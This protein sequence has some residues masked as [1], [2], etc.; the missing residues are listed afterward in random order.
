[1][2]PDTSEAEALRRALLSGLDL[3]SVFKATHP[4]SYYLLLTSLRDVVEHRGDYPRLTGQSAPL[5]TGNPFSTAPTAAPSGWSLPTLSYETRV[6]DALEHCREARAL[7]TI[8]HWIECLNERRLGDFPGPAQTATGTGLALPAPG[9]GFDPGEFLFE[10]LR[11]G[12]LTEA[13]DYLQAHGYRLRAA[14]LLG[15][16]PPYL[17]YRP[18]QERLQ[19]SGNVNVLSWMDLAGR[20]SEDKSYAPYERA[21]FGVLSGNP[22]PM[23]QYLSHMEGR[24]L[25][26]GFGRRFSP[27]MT[28]EDRLWLFARSAYSGFL[29]ASMR[30]SPTACQ[31][32]A[33]AYA[34]IT[35]PLL[36]DE[37]R[38]VVAGD[39]FGL[40]DHINGRLRALWDSE[41]FDELARLCLFSL[42]II[43]EL[44]HLPTKTAEC[45]K[46]LQS[47][48]DIVHEFTE[49]YLERLRVR[50]EEFVP[51]ILES[52]GTAPLATRAG[53]TSFDFAS[54]RIVPRIALFCGYLQPGRAVE[55]L[56]KLTLLI[57]GFY[58]VLLDVSEE[59][60]RR[61]V[62]NSAGAQDWVLIEEVDASGNR[63]TRSSS[64]GDVQLCLTE[65]RRRCLI[66]L[67]KA[68]YHKPA[69]E[70]LG[71]FVFH[72][73]TGTLADGLSGGLPRP[74]GL[75]VSAFLA[76][77]LC[78]SGNPEAAHR[79]C[80][81]A[82]HAF[83]FTS[84]AGVAGIEEAEAAQPRSKVEILE[85]ILKRE[86][87]C[88][89]QCV[90][91]GLLSGWDRAIGEFYASL[92]KLQA[93]GSKAPPGDNQWIFQD[94]EGYGLV[95]AELRATTSNLQS[96]FDWL[97]SG[98]D[99]AMRML[100]NGDLHHYCWEMDNAEAEKIGL[101]AAEDGG[102]PLLSISQE[103]N[104]LEKQYVA[105]DAYAEL[106]KE[107]HDYEEA[108]ASRVARIRS[109][110][111]EASGRLNRRDSES[112]RVAE[113][114]S[115][116]EA[117]A[118]AA[119]A[120]DTAAVA[121]TAGIEGSDANADDSL[122]DF[123]PNP[124][125]TREQNL[126]RMLSRS[127][128]LQALEEKLSGKV[129]LQLCMG[130]A[131]YSSAMMKF[132]AAVTTAEKEETGQRAEAVS[133]L[134]CLMRSN[135]ELT[136]HFRDLSLLPRKLVWTLG[137]PRV[138]YLAHA[139]S[140][141]DLLQVLAYSYKANIASLSDGDNT[142]RQSSSFPPSGRTHAM[143]CAKPFWFGPLRSRGSSEASLSVDERVGDPPYDQSSYQADYPIGDSIGDSIGNSIGESAGDS[144]VAG[145]L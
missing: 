126:T 7:R 61:A 73:L 63:V 2:P 109:E 55:I 53:G 30:Q 24:R 16:I 87:A 37:E 36:T 123:F 124:Q 86:I 75:L 56:L 51:E 97:C 17:E 71:A 14:M 133:Q 47:Y 101:L 68:L 93:C 82:E 54:D 111:R 100:A 44:S 34:R 128:A 135:E 91:Y 131:E 38:F 5:R 69:V 25:G 140:R 88:I 116:D 13:A 4:Q 49:Y 40:F 144:V 137:V 89:D 142:R 33:A 76:R 125:L 64:Y 119:D 136:S 26:E 6:R 48:Q 66:E 106:K 43:R 80:E 77:D 9:P 12:K 1:M 57:R 19:M 21:I 95:C 96:V 121:N 27:G 10:Y 107:R 20:L 28:R 90:K 145:G 50:T 103:L 141:E 98:L 42:T 132:G 79:V 134:R 110:E 117:A 59:L 52:Q 102:G 78:L 62:S 3:D 99:Q 105:S 72:G 92:D 58:P 60:L 120:A 29:N 46:L 67:I 115:V 15:S 45:L 138:F 39:F 8:S 127:V 130:W 22:D 81:Q 112:V 118:G 129:V 104:A 41:A 84:E 114:S 35:G 11:A 23:E 122:I 85:Y 74:E 31:E 65:Y 139:M 113:G 70:E 18:G 108:R 83:G 94:P 143:P 32:A